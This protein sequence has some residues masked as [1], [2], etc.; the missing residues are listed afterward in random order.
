[1]LVLIKTIKLVLIKI[2]YIFN[3]INTSHFVRKKNNSFFS[4]F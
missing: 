1:M 3:K 4:T 2:F